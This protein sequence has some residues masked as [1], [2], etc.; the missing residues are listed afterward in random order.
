[1]EKPKGKLYLSKKAKP[2][3]LRTVDLANFQS[4]RKKSIMIDLKLRITKKTLNKKEK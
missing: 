2:L 4:F 3:G 1:L